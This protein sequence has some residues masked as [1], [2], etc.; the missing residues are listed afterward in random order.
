MIND[1]VR[2]IEANEPNNGDQPIS[3]IFDFFWYLK[4]MISPDIAQQENMNTIK[5]KPSS[6][7]STAISKNPGKIFRTKEI[8]F[9]FLHFL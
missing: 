7:C 1:M 6:N 3:C 8:S 2:M 4:L 9:N 5:S